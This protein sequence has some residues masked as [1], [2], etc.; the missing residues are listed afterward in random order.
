MKLRLAFTDR[1]PLRRTMVFEGRYHRELAM[2]LR[3]KRDVLHERGAVAVWMYESG[4]RR[5]LG[6][7]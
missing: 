3:D 1:W 4:R 2:S 6:E 5:L 7:T